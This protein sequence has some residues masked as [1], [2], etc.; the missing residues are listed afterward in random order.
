MFANIQKVS[1]GKEITDTLYT[2]NMIKYNNV[3]TFPRINISLMNNTCHEVKYI[4]EMFQQ[5]E[6]SLRILHT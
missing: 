1:D 2:W 5:T 4:T 6:I 3:E